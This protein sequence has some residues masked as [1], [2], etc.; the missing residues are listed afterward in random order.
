MGVWNETVG[1]DV[2]SSESRCMPL[3]S[4]G[5]GKTERG[6]SSNV[7]VQGTNLR[8]RETMSPFV[9]SLQITRRESSKHNYYIISPRVIIKAIINQTTSSPLS[10]RFRSMIVEAHDATP[11]RWWNSQRR[12]VSRMPHH[13]DVWTELC[14][15]VQTWFLNRKEEHR[16]QDGPATGG[17]G[18]PPTGGSRTT[19]N[20]G[21]PP[22]RLVHRS[23]WARHSGD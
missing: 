21:T 17:Y 15:G 23:S 9:E 7:S 2:N 3:S 8:Y 4:T 6:L 22:Q 11:I 20:I 12:R 19:K 16:F 10:R 1:E 14:G 5:M 13:E 18:A